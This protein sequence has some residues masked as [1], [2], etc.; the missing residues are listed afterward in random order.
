MAYFR[1]HDP[2]VKVFISTGEWVQFEAATWDIGIYP[3]EGKGISEWLAGEL[4]QCIAR[5]VGGVTEI[6]VQEY[7]ELIKKK[8]TDPDGLV[9]P[10]REELEANFKLNK[11]VL[12][13]I[14]P[15][16]A[17]PRVAVDMHNGAVVVEVPVAAP[18]GTAP[19]PV[20]PQIPRPTASK[21]PLPR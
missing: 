16:D 19:T 9:R 20:A 2:R 6:T 12:P 11:R 5:G 15:R 4:R 17:V 1:N 3:P 18:P 7:E 13:S 8:Q 21:P 10:S 14:G